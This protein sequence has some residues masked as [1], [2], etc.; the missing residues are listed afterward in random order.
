MV[1]D[2]R[3]HTSKGLPAGR[4][5]GVMKMDKK[6]AA[7]IVLSVL[8]GIVFLGYISASLKVHKITAEKGEFMAKIRETEN[9]TTELSKNME[10]L[11]SMLGK[12]QKEKETLA[13]E[14]EEMKNRLGKTPPLDR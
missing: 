12:A 10:D 13:K 3:W 6:D 1:Q 8:L 2:I 5:G 11:K 7:I 14:T 9:L 4:Q